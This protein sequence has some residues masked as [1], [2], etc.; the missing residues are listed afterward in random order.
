M[1]I[2]LSQVDYGFQ[3]GYKYRTPAILALIQQSNYFNAFVYYV[4]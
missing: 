3:E 2:S 1:L 4:K